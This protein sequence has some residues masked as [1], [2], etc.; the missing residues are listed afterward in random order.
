MNPSVQ[1]P[2]NKAWTAA[3]HKMDH[4]LDKKI[5]MHKPQ[6]VTHPAVV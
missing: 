3:D 5:A 6:T 4:V 1:L 2:T